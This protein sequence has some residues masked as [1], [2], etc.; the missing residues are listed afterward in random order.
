MKID[1]NR[2]DQLGAA[3]QAE[4]A[5]RAQQN[6][7]TRAGRPG[8]DNADRVD[9]SPDARLLNSAVAAVKAAPDIRLD[10]VE[11]AKQKLAVGELGNDPLRLADR[12]ID[13]L[14]SR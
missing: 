2:P 8:G 14:L 6:R 13:S 7:T 3:N 11:R 9:L 12:M 5:E 4:A 1:G 10:V